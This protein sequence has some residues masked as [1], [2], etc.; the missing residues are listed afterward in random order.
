MGKRGP[1]PK[2]QH[3]KQLEGNPG[4]RRINRA[5]PVC[6][7]GLSMPDHL[8][9]YARAVWGRIVEAMP[10][11]LYSNC[12]RELLAAYCEAADLHRR[13]VM[14]V[15]VEGEVTVGESGAPYQN[16]WVSI[17]NRQAQ[18]LATLGTR[19]GLDPAARSSLAVPDAERP[20]SKFEGLVA[21]KGGR[22]A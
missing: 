13:A 16:P 9:E 19:L 21:I 20:E 8:G 18:L 7:G 15:R 10:P 4:K 2:P 1:A 22:G 14:A 11:R 6:D 12:D 3:L 17:L 5:A